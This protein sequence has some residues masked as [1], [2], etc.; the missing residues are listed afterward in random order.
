MSPPAFGT[1]WDSG[2]SEGIGDEGGEEEGIIDDEGGEEEELTEGDDYEISEPSE[3]DDED[4]GSSGEGP[5]GHAWPDPFDEGTEASTPPRS[6]RESV[7]PSDAELTPAA[8]AAAAAAHSCEGGREP[9]SAE[10]ARR[11]LEEQAGQSSAASSTSQVADASADGAGAGAA[12]CTVPSAPSTAP[13]AQRRPGGPMGRKLRSAASGSG[14]SSSS[15]RDPGD[16]PLSPEVAGLV[17]LQRPAAGVSAA[18]VSELWS[19]ADQLE[20]LT[21]NLTEQHLWSPCG[22]G[23][24]VADALVGGDDCEEDEGEDLLTDFEEDGFFISA[25]GALQPVPEERSCEL[26]CD[27]SPGHS[28]PL[29]AYVAATGALLASSAET[30]GVTAADGTGG[31][32]VDAGASA[33]AQAAAARTI[34]RTARRRA[35]AAAAASETAAGSVPRPS[36]AA[37]RPPSP[38]PERQQP[39]AEA[40]RQHSPEDRLRAQLL[41]QQLLMPVVLRSILAAQDIAQRHRAEA[42]ALVKAAEKE[43]E[44]TSAAA[45]A[46]DCVEETEAVLTTAA[47][48]EPRAVTPSAAAADAARFCAGHPGG[49]AVA[50][51][52]DAAELAEAIQVAALAEAPAARPPSAG[53][54]GASAARASAAAVAARPAG[55]AAAVGAKPVAGCSSSST[56]QPRPGRHVVC[57]VRGSG[58]LVAPGGAPT[59]P[60]PLPPRPDKRASVPRI[61]PSTSRRSCG[62]SETPPGSAEA[63]P[64]REAPGSLALATGDVDAEASRAEV[65][66]PESPAHTDCQQEPPCYEV[67]EEEFHRLLQAGA[68]VEQAGDGEAAA[69]EYWEISEEEFERLMQ[70]GQLFPAACEEDVGDIEQDSTA[71]A[72][73]EVSEEQ[74]E[75][76]A[77]AGALRSPSAADADAPPAPAPEQ[78]AVAAAAAAAAR[79]RPA[80]GAGGAGG[81]PQSS[82]DCSSGLPRQT[83]Q[84]ASQSRETRRPR[85]VDCALITKSKGKREQ[86][87]GCAGGL[88][89]LPTDAVP[90]ASRGGSPAEPS[91]HSSRSGSS[92]SS[93]PGG[94]ESHRGPAEEDFS[95][96]KVAAGA[97]LHSARLLRELRPAGGEARQRRSMS[98]PP[99]GGEASPPAGGS[100]AADQRSAPAARGRRP[101]ALPR[102][103]PGKLPR[104]PPQGQPAL[105]LQPLACGAD[106]AGDKVGAAS[107]ATSEIARRHGHGAGAVRKVASLLTC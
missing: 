89:F 30:V 45:L 39:P 27:G 105:S 104:L 6:V 46:A 82:A 42:E 87:G 95:R 34:Q 106:A 20:E 25:G 96:I 29:L 2:A 80:A 77:V 54:S 26:S 102:T 59:R 7:T 53:S 99:S 92:A 97:P 14:S 16:A 107:P 74:F 19:L 23:P 90:S 58:R 9:L 83:R 69:A 52:A 48:V 103:A 73:Y 88:F 66:C 17:E 78:A 98:V 51:L 63:T 57:A 24:D 5:R 86:Q 21:A 75:R 4:A 50:A 18:G 13:P 81:A 68:V 72:A 3:Y 41:A 94:G 49:D 28:A 15:S 100:A 62:S 64:R 76:L 40:A 35:A 1:D 22:E 56:R 44:A 55:A 60:R 8:A 91:A 33:E 31:V 67:S 65:A 47:E 36:E 37:A 32:E 84:P 70:C 79:R 38:P 43:A 12:R 93:C 85:S 11:L 71:L 101:L 10:L 61:K